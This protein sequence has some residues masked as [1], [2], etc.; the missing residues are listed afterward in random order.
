MFAIAG[1]YYGVRLVEY[2]ATTIPSQYLPLA[3]PQ[4]KALS[5]PIVAFIIY[6]IINQATRKKHRSISK[7]NKGIINVLAKSAFVR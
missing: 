1:A 6:T 5:V 4:I 2:I 3:V 7:K